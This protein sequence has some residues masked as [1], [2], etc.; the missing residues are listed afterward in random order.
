M[1]DRTLAPIPFDP[2]VRRATTTWLGRG[3]LFV[4][5][6]FLLEHARPLLLPVTI[7]IVFTFVLA[8]PVQALRR[9]GGTSTSA[10][11]SSS[12]PCSAPR[13]SS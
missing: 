2:A 7:A 10:R 5:I 6:V 4:A 11:R 13:R 9:A 3:L 1:I 12:P 8:A